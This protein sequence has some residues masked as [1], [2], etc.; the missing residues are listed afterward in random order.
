MSTHRLQAQ[1]V[2][3]CAMLLLS[4][5]MNLL[6]FG[7]S[8][9]RY[10]VEDWCTLKGYLPGCGSAE[11]TYF[12]DGILRPKIYPTTNMLCIHSVGGKVIDTV[13][14]AQVYGLPDNPPYFV[15]PNKKTTNDYT[16]N[17]HSLTPDRIN[18]SMK[19]Y[20]EMVGVP[21]LV[22]LGSVLWDV[23]RLF[24]QNEVWKSSSHGELDIMHSALFNS[25]VVEYE[26]N[27][28]KALVH[29]ED[30]LMMNL[31][32]TANTT[33]NRL[34]AR[35]RIGLRTAVWNVANGILVAA[36]NN[37]I[38]AVASQL[39]LTLYDYDVD[40]WSSLAHDRSKEKL[41]L[42]DFV[43]PSQHYTALAAEKMLM[44]VY[45]GAMTYR[46]LMHDNIPRVWWAG[47]RS[48]RPQRISKV[49]LAQKNDDD[50]AIEKRENRAFYL[51]CDQQNA[52]IS[53]HGD[54]TKSF[55]FAMSLGPED[56]L[57]LSL[58]ALE[59]IP[60]GHPIPHEMFSHGF[61]GFVNDSITGALWLVSN[62]QKRQLPRDA[63]QYYHKNTSE[64]VL[65][66]NTTSFFFSLIPSGP[67]IPDIY[68][69]NTL[70]RWAGS[71]SVFLLRDGR[72]HSVPRAQIFF[73]N[74]WEFS[75]VKVIASME[76]L[77]IVPE[78]ESL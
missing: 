57:L 45:S 55:I 20:F 78:G 52:V 77:A 41:L 5:S 21:D 54:A 69:N 73:D 40:L 64:P 47:Q 39:K 61:R 4:R 65:T 42:R 48:Q 76:D 32:M 75:Q 25:S 3:I 60:E 63:L 59:T 37:V 35:K 10:M 29:L 34:L 66:F 18:V 56:I 2:V 67:A 16:H 9:D 71:K 68:A 24:E 13:A 23:G 7:D 53:R 62:G 22:V 38:R 70:V 17:W 28:R 6:S 26:S 58:D 14:F 11:C 19:A 50:A 72:I 43:H 36:F 1:L 31:N 74:G 12:L 30:N 44:N 8:V 51:E 33:N 15:G 46:G 49:L 27:L